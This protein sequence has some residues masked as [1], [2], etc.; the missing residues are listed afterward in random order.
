MNNTILVHD[1]F[2]GALI[3]VCWTTMLYFG[4]S[5]YVDMTKS[6]IQTARHIKYQ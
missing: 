1:E 3:A 4:M 5:G 2:L 6:I